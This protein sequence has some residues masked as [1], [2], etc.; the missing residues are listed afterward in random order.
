LLAG[1]PLSEPADAAQLPQS[2]FN[3]SMR[4]VKT[5]FLINPDSF[6]LG[7]NFTDLS[8]VCNPYARRVIATA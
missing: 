8:A 6:V 7:P 4:P 3:D 2:S 1:T 5:S